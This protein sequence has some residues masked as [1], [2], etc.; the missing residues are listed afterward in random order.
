MAVPVHCLVTSQ[1]PQTRSATADI[2]GE[3]GKCQSTCMHGPTELQCMQVHFYADFLNSRLAGGTSTPLPSGCSR[4]QL[5]HACQDGILLRF[6]SFASVWCGRTS[7]W[8]CPAPGLLCSQRTYRL[9]DI[10]LARIILL[11]SS[12]A[13]LTRWQP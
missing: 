5:V 7:P 13:C 9:R 3:R 10:K 11:D 6:A 1:S 4:D 12:Q 8:P 2:A